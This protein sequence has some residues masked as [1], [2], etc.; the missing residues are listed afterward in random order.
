MQ[1]DELVESKATLDGRLLL[2]MATDSVDLTVT[3]KKT[4]SD[5]SVEA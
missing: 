4:Y 5:K 3:V 1:D 2:D